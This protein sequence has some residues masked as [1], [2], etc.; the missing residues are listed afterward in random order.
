MEC[1]EKVYRT[2]KSLEKIL[3]QTEEMAKETL[4]ALRRAIDR[5]VSAF[6]ETILWENKKKANMISFED[7]LTFYINSKKEG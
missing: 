7:P 1:E 3:D 4:E 2:L 6:P 5:T